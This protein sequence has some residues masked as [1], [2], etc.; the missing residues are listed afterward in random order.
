MQSHTLL[1]THRVSWW[2]QHCAFEICKRQSTIA[3][4][5]LYKQKMCWTNCM[6]Y[7][8]RQDTAYIQYTCTQYQDVRIQHTSR[9]H[10]CNASA[11]MYMPSWYVLSL[12]LYSCR[13]LCCHTN[14]GLLFFKFCQLRSWGFHCSLLSTSHNSQLNY[15]D[16]SKDLNCKFHCSWPIINCHR[17]RWIQRIPCAFLPFC[18]A[19]LGWLY[20]DCTSIRLEGACVYTYPKINGWFLFACCL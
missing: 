3:N 8:R 19:L 15:F 5:K 6:R 20:I 7:S 9:I 2:R 12:Q 4:T 11:Q 18:K 10:V 13:V 1:R 14:A 16:Q 17:V